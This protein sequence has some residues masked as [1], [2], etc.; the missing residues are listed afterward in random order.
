MKNF[1]GFD[2]RTVTGNLGGRTCRNTFAQ[3]LPTTA[4]SFAAIAL[5]YA[6]TQWYETSNFSGDTTILHGQ[7]EVIAVRQ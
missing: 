7:A 3:S 6:N 1:L 5:G 4:S 2:A